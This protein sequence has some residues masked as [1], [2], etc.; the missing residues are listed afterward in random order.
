MK[1]NLETCGTLIKKMINIGG[2]VEK[3]ILKLE[4]AAEKEW[5]SYSKDKQRKAVDLITEDLS[6]QWKE[7]GTEDAFHLLQALKKI[8][9]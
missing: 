3:K 1:N 9:V 5:L 6:R 4:S 2:I 7:N 8:A